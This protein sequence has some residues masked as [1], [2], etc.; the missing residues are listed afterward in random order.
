MS[1]SEIHIY[2]K[3]DLSIWV[4]VSSRSPQ[5]KARAF[6]PFEGLSDLYTHGYKAE[7]ESSSYFEALRSI[8]K[9]YMEK[10]RQT[11]IV[12]AGPESQRKDAWRHGKQKSSSLLS[13]TSGWVEIPFEMLTEISEEELALELE[14]TGKTTVSSRHLKGNPEVPIFRKVSLEI[15]AFQFEFRTRALELWKPKCAISGA[16]C[17]LEAA[18]IKGVAA[19][20]PENSS[21]MLNPYNSIIL[22]VALHGLLDE[23]LIS[24]SDEG[25]LLVSNTLSLQDQSIFGV[26]VPKKIVFNPEAFPFLK[27]HRDTVFRGPAR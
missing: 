26:D 11:F 27:Y 7:P 14:L 9:A 16:T 22:N 10:K 24:F 20:K 19:S 8:Q 3:G 13:P 18:H 25:V 17:L 5:R 1:Q 23:G 4:P 6:L 2:Q 12:E 15:R 21:D